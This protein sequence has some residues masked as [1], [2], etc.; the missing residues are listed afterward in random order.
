MG[1]IGPM[2]LTGAT[3]PQGPVGETGASGP[4]GPAGATG[5]QGA[6]GIPGLNG[7]SVLNGVGTPLTTVGVDGDFYLDTQA[8]VLYG[9]KANGEWNAGVSLIG[10][11]GTGFVLGTLI[12][13]PSDMIAPEGYVLLGTFQQPVKLV[14]PNA[15]SNGNTAVDRVLNI[16]VYQLKFIPS[17]NNTTATMNSTP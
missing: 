17:P 11:R 2:G 3:G 16:A 10:A 14:V 7:H 15:K 8:T 5:S 1:P 12:Y 13:L 6:Q 4:Q 9:P